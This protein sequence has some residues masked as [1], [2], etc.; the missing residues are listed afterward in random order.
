[1]LDKGTGEVMHPVVGPLVEAEQL[2]A[3]PARLSE[4]L[5]ED[6]ER[7]LVVYDVGMG[8][9]SLAAV[10]LRASE[11]RRAGRCMHM[12]SFDRTTAALELAV[13][14]RHRG[15][16]GF[17]GVLADSALE[18]IARGHFES[19]RTSWRL[20]KAELPG[21]LATPQPP[22]DIVFWDPFSPR[23]NP[24]LWSV[25]A[26]AALRSVCAAGATVHT[27]SGATATR[28]AMLLAGVAVGLGP[29]T[30]TDRQATIAAI[31]AADLTQPLDHRWLLR[32]SRSSAAFPPD[33]PGDA[34]RR[35]EALAQFDR[36]A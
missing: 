9:G 10:A 1:M 29:T 21:A 16:F 35:I 20:V 11:S 2:Y 23:A 14:E 4:R 18:L 24:S 6:L 17:D 13:E 33:A 3:I 27:Y 25:E 19:D 28:S 22:A 26:F 34:L 32:L 12:I 5:A 7:A 31:D 15:D 8:A 36:N 30:S